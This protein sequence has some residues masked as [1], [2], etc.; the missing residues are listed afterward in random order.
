[1]LTTDNLLLPLNFFY[2]IFY[3]W[4]A[5]AKASASYPYVVGMPYGATKKG[6]K[7]IEKEE[8]NTEKKKKSA[9]KEERT[10]EKCT[11]VNIIR[12]SL[13]LEFFE[14]YHGK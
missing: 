14:V 6:K 3:S 13:P 10:C 12:G 4:E 2:L 8:G 9:K 11:F 7:K 5:Y 1:L